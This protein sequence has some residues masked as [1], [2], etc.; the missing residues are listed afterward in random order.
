MSDFGHYF[1]VDVKPILNNKIIKILEIF[2]CLLN[3]LCNSF[4]LKSKP[5]KNSW[6]I[7]SAITFSTV[8]LTKCGIYPILGI[9]YFDLK[10]IN[11]T[12]KPFNIF[13]LF[14]F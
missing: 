10:V 14:N 2:L 7:I 3:F 5:F 9:D 13:K 11:F 12:N 8:S 4:H 6:A 1:R